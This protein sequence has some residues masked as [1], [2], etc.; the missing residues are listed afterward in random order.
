MSDQQNIVCGS[1]VLD[2]E[3]DIYLA[4]RGDALVMESTGCLANE[5]QGAVKLVSSSVISL[6]AGTTLIGLAGAGETEG[7]IAVAAPAEG[8]IKMGCGVPELGPRILMEP[9]ML[10]LEIG[11]PG[12]GA[13][14]TMTPESITF[15]VAEVSVTLT[16]EGINEMVAE[17]TREVTPQ[18]HNLTAAETEFNIGVQGVAWEGPTEAQ[19][20]EGGTVENETL[21]SHTTDAA[22]NED[23]GIALEV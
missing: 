2:A 23:A 1:Y 17:V 3:E 11:P 9:E 7:Q 6:T 4:C 20:V 16:P 22:K 15:K 8:S 10:K 13:G 19:E 14:I 5:Y 12:A 18:G 21:G